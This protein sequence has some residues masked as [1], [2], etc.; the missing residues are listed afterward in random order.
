MTAG[1]GIA[2]ASGVAGA[3]ARRA[4]EPTAGRQGPAEYR[5]RNG[6]LKATLVAMSEPALVNGVLTA[7]VLSY[8]GYFP[9]PMLRVRPGDRLQIRLVNRTLLPTNLHFH[10]MHVSPKGHQDNV[11]VQVDPG[12][13]FEYDVRIPKDHPRGLYWYHPHFHPDVDTQVW[14]GLA[15]LLLVEG[16]VT[17]LPLIRDVP[18]REMSIRQAA[19]AAPSQYDVEQ[20]Q[21]LDQQIN[22]VDGNVMP[23]IDIRPGETQLWR[24]ANIGSSAYYRLAI[25]GARMTV[26]EDD[27]GVVYRTWEPD[28]LLMPPG[29][30]FGVLV[31]APRVPKQLKLV[32]L[33]YY[34]GPFGDWPA[35]DLASVHVAG[36]QG[37]SITVPEKL[38][39]QPDWV[40]GPV[41][42]RRVLTLGETPP[43]VFPPTFYINGVPF[44]KMTF[45]D[46]IQATLGTTE[47]WVV[48]NAT[49]TEGG[50][51]NEAHPFHLHVN[52]IVIV[53][54]G[55]WDPAT[56]EISNVRK[57]DP[58][59]AIDTFN[60]PW[61]SYV[62]FRTNFSDF[63]GRT[64]YHCHILF[65]EDHGMMGVVD[66]LDAE[67]KGVGA[68]QQLPMHH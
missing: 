4:K 60:V 38:S 12:G 58:R 67:G 32:T 59:S 11:F 10:G 40:K 9:G 15:G 26:V 5:S 18:I 29:K 45:A 17:E 30:R 61:N 39:E 42:K 25:P 36:R 7:G 24:F 22:L 20:M 1:V 63:T 65:H 62:K 28:S 50:T 31:T 53:E 56:N 66:I 41:A 8:N 14:R 37:R 21:P 6:V 64:V 49:S 2:A 23:K 34:Q 46:V 16:G 54:S 43:D 47:E 13:T 57:V 27:G 35:A 55:D 44:E 48:R 33:G 68:D 51:I 19:F 52:D 3:Q